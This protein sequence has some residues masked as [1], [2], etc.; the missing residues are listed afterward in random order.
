MKW[1]NFRRDS[2]AD[3]V[4]RA[5]D[6]V[7]ARR[8]RLLLVV[9]W[10]LSC[11]AVWMLASYRAAPDLLHM[12]SEL[13]SN[14]SELERLRADLEQSE[15]KLS[16]SE[17]SDQVSR[18]ANES[19][20]AT[21]R[22]QEDEIA[23]LR[24]DIAF[25][26]RLM[27]GKSGRKG[28]TVHDLAVRPITGGRGYNLRATLTQNLRKGEV[29]RGTASI[30]IEGLQDGKIVSLAWDS[31]SGRDPATPPEFSFKYFQQLDSSF[32]LPEGFTPNRIRL[33]VKSEQGDNSEQAF[34]WSQALSIGERNEIW[35]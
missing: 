23:G 1:F 20:Q 16:I 7:G 2:A 35:R 33:A 32:V 13:R 30:S 3:L 11:V 6:P 34:A 21:L 31:L 24:S 5:H 8:Q 9:A 29:T 26:Q 22:A 27:D 25:F 17:K 12:H 14:R 4:L 19:L 10:L 15:R 18:T 28:L